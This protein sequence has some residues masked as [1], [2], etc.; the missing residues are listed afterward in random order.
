MKYLLRSLAVL[1]FLLLAVAPAFAQDRFVFTDEV[2]NLD[3]GRIERAAQP[4]LNQGAEVAI[5]M[6]QQGSDADF[7][8]RLEVDGLVRGDQARVGLIGIYVGLDNRYSDIRFG[9][10]W[11]EALRTN[12]NFEA[13]R[14]NQLNPGL[15]AGEFTQGYV[16]ALEAIAEAVANPPQPGG[17][18]NIVVDTEGV[19]DNLLFPVAT[20]AVGVTGVVIGWRVIRRRRKAAQALASARQQFEEARQDA[21]NVIAIMG[22]L[23]KD[24]EEKAAFDRVSYAAADVERLAQAQNE[25]KQRFSNAQLRFDEVGET[26]ERYA[27]PTIPQYNEAA[28]GY[29]QVQELVTNLRT[30]LDQINAQ[31]I[32]LDKLAQQAPGEIDNAKKA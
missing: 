16:D 13:I 10:N 4:L 6:V 30:Q 27:N 15:A 2:G 24:A 11:N 8:R 23:L 20:G 3:Q 22:Q 14:N 32:E 5:Y 26:L 9:D 18:T 17:G 1:A 31:R 29:Q 21:G 25:V 12:D 7:L 28:Q 19:R